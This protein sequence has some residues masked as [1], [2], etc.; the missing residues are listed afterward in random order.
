M[1]TTPRRI[2]VIG[3]GV[4]GSWAAL[5]LAEVGV[6]T[7]LVEQ[8]HLP[9]GR[10]S[11]HGASRAFRYLGDET[12][13][14][15][16]YSWERWRALEGA[17]GKTLFV[18]TGLLNF[19]PPGDSWLDRHMDIVRAAGKPCE[20][21]DAG[22]IR[23]RLP[24]VRYPEEWGAAWDP[25]GGILYA[26]RCL[27][28]VQARFRQ[29]GGRLITAR[30]EVVTDRADDQVD[31]EIRRPGASGTELHRCAGAVVTCGPWT[32]TLLP[33]LRSLLRTSAI[34]VT[35]WHDPSGECSVARGF[36]ILY[37]ARLTDIY[38]LPGHEYHGLVKVLYHGGP[39]AEPD[40]RDVPDRQPYVDRVRRYVRRH[41]PTLDSRG[42]AL[43]ET[44]M[45]THTPDGE[46]V[47]DRLSENVVVGCGFSGSGFKHSPAT[48]HMLAALALGEEG[49][50][51][52]GYR[53]PRYALGRFHDVAS[54]P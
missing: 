40:S 15:L 34:P 14:R 16:D 44:C 38:A 6:E 27:S 49:R 47:L 29:M 9:H 5:H 46:P 39:E 51:P 32:S 36:P 43:E 22:A 52:E 18:R 19:G 37:N 10:G 11:S 23:S 13:D 41:L 28:A 2:C 50:L 7:V 25:N 20:W 53:L 48:G 24:H 42:P 26:H 54:R 45:Y 30:A 4:I 1:T 8:F 33:E 35:Y 21:L 17:M 3:G 12:M 31:V